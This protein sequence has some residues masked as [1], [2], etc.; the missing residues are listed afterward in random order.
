MSLQH[1]QAF[2]TFQRFTDLSSETIPE[3][4]LVHDTIS[5]YRGVYPLREYDWSQR[6]S[7]QYLFWQ[8]DDYHFLNSYDFQQNVSEDGETLTLTSRDEFGNELRFI[9]HNEMAIAQLLKSNIKQVWEMLSALAANHASDEEIEEEE[10]E[11]FRLMKTFQRNNIIS[12]FP[13]I[14]TN[15][16]ARQLV[17]RLDRPANQLFPVANAYSHILFRDTDSWYDFT[18]LRFSNGNTFHTPR[19]LERFHNE[20]IRRFKTAEISHYTDVTDEWF[21]NNFVWSIPEGRSNGVLLYP[22]LTPQVEVELVSEPNDVCFAGVTYWNFFGMDKNP[23]FEWYVDNELQAETSE[24][25][26]FAGGGGLV[27][28][29]VKAD[30]CLGN[31]RTASAEH[32]KIA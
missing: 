15:E 1:P 32:Y 18:A 3:N 20:V 13:E 5:N 21:V 6:N 29:V 23:R 4:I 24:R 28:C 25:F 2:T 7:G 16:E 10:D 8:V 30:D 17:E 11:L 12:T 26:S 14:F 19:Q 9:V 27:R 31:E 22:S